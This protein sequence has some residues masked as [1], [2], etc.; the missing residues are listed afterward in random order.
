[1]S[2]L[3]SQFYPSL[4]KLPWLHS[5]CPKNYW[6]DIENQKKF[7][8]WAEKQLQIKN[9]NDWYNITA[10]VMFLSSSQKTEPF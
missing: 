4:E 2:L 5:K 8:T 10:K 9:K 6:D 3:L 1:M 7:I